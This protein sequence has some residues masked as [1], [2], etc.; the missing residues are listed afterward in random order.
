[1]SKRERAKRLTSKPLDRLVGVIKLDPANLLS[2][3]I[4]VKQLTDQGREVERTFVVAVADDDIPLRHGDIRKAFESGAHP[5]NLM[6]GF[7]YR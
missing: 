5:S 1:M 4:K 3:S 7:I 2:I 6:K